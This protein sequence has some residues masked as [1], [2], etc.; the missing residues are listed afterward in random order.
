MYDRSQPGAGDNE[1]QRLIVSFMRTNKWRKITEIGQDLTPAER[2]NFLWAW[3]LEQDVERLG[4]TLER[5]TI[6]SI[7]SVGCGNGLL[8]WI[9]GCAFHAISVIGIEIDQEW[10]DSKYAPARYIPLTFVNG[11]AGSVQEVTQKMQQDQI[12]ALL[13]CYFNNGDAFE[14]YVA[15]FGGRFVIL[16]GPKNEKGVHTNPL[17]MAPGEQFVQK[18]KL[19]EHFDIGSENINCVA[20]YERMPAQA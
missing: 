2:S 5:L 4:A 11:T 14:Q 1:D 18:W 10:W 17:P 16:I 15:G 8:E 7:A 20:I 13:F 19:L 6:R 9:I 3:P 12:D